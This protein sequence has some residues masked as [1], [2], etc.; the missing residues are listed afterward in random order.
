MMK[1]WPYLVGGWLVMHGLSALIKLNFRYDDVVMGAL[2]LVA[3]V[4][5]IIRR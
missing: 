5:V 4:F 2:A 3:G 1:L